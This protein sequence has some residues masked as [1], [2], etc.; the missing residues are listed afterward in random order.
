[1]ENSDMRPGK[2][3]D[4]GTQSKTGG[5]R[6]NLARVLRLM[7][8]LL[9]MGCNE[10][11][12]CSETPTDPWDKIQ[13]FL[14]NAQ[15][16][17]DDHG[18]TLEL[19]WNCPGDTASLLGYELVYQEKSGSKTFEIGKR[20]CQILWHVPS[21]NLVLNANYDQ[22]GKKGFVASKPISLPAVVTPT[23]T[24]Y[25]LSDQ[26]KPNGFRFDHTDWSALGIT[27]AKREA[28]GTWFVVKD[29]AD[30]L[31]LVSPS[32]IMPLGEWG[33]MPN[34]VVAVTEDF[35]DLSQCPN[36]S[37]ATWSLSTELEVG[38]TYALWHEYLGGEIWNPADQF[39]KLKV[40]AID[41]NEVTLKLAVQPWPA[42]RWV[43]T[44]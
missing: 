23:F 4:G 11:D 8:L 1:M 26:T 31:L 13:D 28:A 7:P 36:T 2:G 38:R 21:A 18:G 40:L 27:F 6:W 44:P 16:N 43:L 22:G 14:L 17:W 24:L 9:L 3:T 29:S 15:T 20:D 19:Q 12:K 30:K 33:Q 42:L 10:T 37:E 41:S 34:R 32:E 25:G 39:A 35:D 5:R